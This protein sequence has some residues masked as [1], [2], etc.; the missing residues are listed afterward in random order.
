MQTAGSSE[1]TG[2][3]AG[4]G[5]DS[6]SAPGPSNQAARENSEPDERGRAAEEPKK[7]TGDPQESR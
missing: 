2:G 5:S 7:E 4:G 1:I 6:T 3:V